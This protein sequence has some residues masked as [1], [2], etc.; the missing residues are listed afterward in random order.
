MFEVL[1][2]CWAMHLVIGVLLIN[3]PRRQDMK[4]LRMSLLN[5]E[6]NAD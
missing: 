5:Q 3:I 2:L 4:N 6:V 1:A